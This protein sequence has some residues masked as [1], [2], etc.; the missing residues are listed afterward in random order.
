[1][2]FSAVS[3]ARSMVLDPVAVALAPVRGICHR[4]RVN[5]SEQFRGVLSELSNIALFALI[6]YLATIHYLPE[7]IVGMLLMGYA[8]A[9][10]S[11]KQAN[12]A[13]LAMSQIA[14]GT[15]YQAQ[16]T[17]ASQRMQ[18]VKNG[19]DSDGDGGGG[20]GGSGG[21]S[22][23]GVPGERAAVRPGSYSGPPLRYPP[24]D[25][26]TVFGL[27]TWAWQHPSALGWAGTLAALV[28]FMAL[29]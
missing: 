22:P 16:A 11:V 26:R 10:W 9:R 13:A 5:P 24:N 19:N 17:S 12:G 8:T 4:W 1:M 18:A 28:A 25:R 3:A 2:A 27:A 7:S 15:V 6:G 29:R 23:P 21:A 20:G 14:S